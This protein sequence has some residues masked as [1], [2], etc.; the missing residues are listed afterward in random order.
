MR[1]VLIF[2]LGAI[3]A[4]TATFVLAEGHSGRLK[5]VARAVCA[6]SGLVLAALL[7]SAYFGFVLRGFPMDW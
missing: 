6:A 2:V 3:F 1:L 5:P 4:A 7:I